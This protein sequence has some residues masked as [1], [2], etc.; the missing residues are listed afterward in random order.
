MGYGAGGGRGGNRHRRMFNM[1]GIPG[2]MRFG[3]SPGW[4]DRSPNGLPPMAQ[5]LMS[6]GLMPQFQDYLQNMQQS[7]IGSPGSVP[8]SGQTSDVT[9]MP[10]MPF[11]PFTSA[12]PKEQE[13]QMLKQQSEFLKQQLQQIE[14][15]LRELAEG[16]I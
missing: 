15:R 7:G 9:G 10:N 6:S 13:L 16:E 12:I 4:A 8:P 1:T 3:F 14:A 11:T 2:W 5:W